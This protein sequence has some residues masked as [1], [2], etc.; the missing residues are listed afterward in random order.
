[1]SVIK[2]GDTADVTMTSSSNSLSDPEVRL[3]VEYS[4]NGS[5]TSWYTAEMLWSRASL[6]FPP[7]SSTAPAQTLTLRFWKPWTAVN[8]FASFKSDM[9]NE[10]STEL[11]PATTLKVPLSRGSD[12]PDTGLKS[13]KQ[14]ETA[15]LL[16]SGSD[17]VICNSPLSRLSVDRLSEGVEESRTRRSAEKADAEEI[18]EEGFPTSSETTPCVELTKNVELAATG[19]HVS[20]SE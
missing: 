19:P 17:H 3:T 15:E 20:Y 7:K 5:D 14:D 2:A 1:M 12:T 9:D 10:K 18:A 16:D 6:S 11:V 13:V 4:S 8:A